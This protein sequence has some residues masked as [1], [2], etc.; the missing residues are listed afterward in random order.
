MSPEVTKFLIQCIGVLFIW[1]AIDYKRP[2]EYRFSI[3]SLDGLAQ[4]VLVT[5]GLTIYTS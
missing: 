1:I 2:L 5:I 3:F 4:L